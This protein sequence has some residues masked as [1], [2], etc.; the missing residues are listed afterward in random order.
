MPHYIAVCV[1]IEHCHI[2]V[3]DS[4][5]RRHPSVVDNVFWFLQWHARQCI[6]FSPDG[7]HERAYV[8]ELLADLQTR[9][10]TRH[11]GGTGAVLQTNGKDCGAWVLFAI[12][13][14]I[15]GLW[16]FSDVAVASN[17]DYET[18]LVQIMRQWMRLVL[19]T[20]GD[21]FCDLKDWRAV[22]ESPDPKHK[23]MTWG[24]DWLPELHNMNP[25]AVNS[26]RGVPEQYLSPDSQGIP[27]HSAQQQIQTT[28]GDETHDNPGDDESKSA[29]SSQAAEGDSPGEVEDSEDQQSVD[30]KPTEGDNPGEDEDSEDQQSDDEEG[31]SD[32]EQTLAEGDQTLDKGTHQ[33]AS[34][35]DEGRD[36]NAA[37]GQNEPKCWPKLT[38]QE[39]VR[40]LTVAIMRTW[41]SASGQPATG[42]KVELCQRLMKHAAEGHE[43]EQEKVSVGARTPLQIIHALQARG[44]PVPSNAALR[45][46][47]LRDYF[48]GEQVCAIASKPIGWCSFLCMCAILVFLRKFV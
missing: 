26:A 22:V 37:A 8:Q 12:L 4:L 41:L 24:A 40:K 48:V 19:A 43:S 44:L 47:Q 18:Q 7:A 23:W 46:R 29:S 11:Y 39:A 27:V 42:N 17:K 20:D 2:Y 38:E 32:S 6:Q 33:G 15:R 31:S 45:Y 3:F 14:F 35:D 9:W 21:C 1:D 36:D 34:D 30:E 10:V 16:P 13:Y 25:V 28:E 5:H